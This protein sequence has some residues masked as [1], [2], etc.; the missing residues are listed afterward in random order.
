MAGCHPADRVRVLGLVFT[1]KLIE[2][3]QRMDGSQSLPGVKE[4]VFLLVFFAVFLLSLIHISPFTF[5]GLS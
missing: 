4:V 1:L 2:I 3:S 5:Q